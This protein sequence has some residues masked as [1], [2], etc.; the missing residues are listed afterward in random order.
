MET[1]LKLLP[2]DFLSMSGDGPLLTIT[3]CEPEPPRLRLSR[4]RPPV[5]L[6]LAKTVEFLNISVDETTGPPKC[7]VPTN[8]KWS[9]S[10]R[11]SN[12]QP[13]GGNGAQPTYPPPTRQDTQAGAHSTPGTQTQP[14]AGS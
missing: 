3:F 10:G 1:V 14:K 8:T 11:C 12:T 9:G 6:V 4:L 2:D 13:A 5:S 7:A